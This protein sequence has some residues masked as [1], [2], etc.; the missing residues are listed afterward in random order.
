MAC[1]RMWTG[2]APLLLVT[3]PFPLH[4]GTH[5]LKG[6]VRCVDLHV[7]FQPEDA[8]IQCSLGQS[9][10][11]VAI[12]Q[13]HEIEGGLRTQAEGSTGDLDLRAR[14]CVGIKL[15]AYRQRAID[16]RRNPIVDTSRLKRDRT[17]DVP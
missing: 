1:S 16:C 10:L 15:I 7:R 2:K 17:F 4:T 6:E 11:D 3:W 13:I 14:I 8:D 12:V 5:D 9:Y